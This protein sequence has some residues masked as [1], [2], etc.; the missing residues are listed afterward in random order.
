MQNLWDEKT[1]LFTKRKKK[2]AE[3]LHKP[4]LRNYLPSD[5]SILSNY[6]FHLPGSKFS[7]TWKITG[8]VMT[9]LQNLLLGALFLSGIIG[10]ER[11]RVEQKHLQSQVANPC[12]TALSNGTVSRCTANFYDSRYANWWLIKSD[13]FLTGYW[14]KLQN[15]PSNT[16]HFANKATTNRLLQPF[17]ILFALTPSTLRFRNCDVFLYIYITW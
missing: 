4:N 2:S 12:G 11:I 10:L 3:A 9:L 7:G 14:S 8:P 13:L 15:R 5:R 6:W 1:K 16:W 17:A